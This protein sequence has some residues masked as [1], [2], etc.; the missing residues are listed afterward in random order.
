MITASAAATARLSQK[1]PERCAFFAR[2]GLAAAGAAADKGAGCGASTGRED[3]PGRAVVSSVE[4]AAGD[5]AGLGEAAAGAAAL[6]GRLGVV[7]GGGGA[8]PSCFSPWSG[9]GLNTVLLP[10]SPLIAPR[11]LAR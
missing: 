7:L 2:F 6:T 8:A 4:R 11:P 5:G 10:S 1:P 3:A 9:D